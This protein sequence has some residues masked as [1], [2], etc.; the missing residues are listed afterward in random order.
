VPRLCKILD[1]SVS[2]YYAWQNRPPSKRFQEEA[3]LEVEIR[4]SHKRTRETCGPERLQHDLAD[5][6]VKVGICRIK[7]IR[8]KLG[9]YCKQ[10]RK[11]R[12]TTDSKHTL[13]VAENILNQKFQTKAP[14]QVWVTDMSYVP[15]EEGT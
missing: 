4:A 3:R 12:V 11:F 13:P 10:K 7:R 1:V 8:K 6:G 5:H 14:N 15:A 9:I 2:S